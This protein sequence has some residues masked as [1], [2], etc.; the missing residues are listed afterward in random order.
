MIGLISRVKDL[1]MF[2]CFCLLEI[3]IAQRSPEFETPTLCL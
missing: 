1:I 3:M 2:M